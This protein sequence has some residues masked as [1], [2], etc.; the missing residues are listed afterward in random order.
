MPEG[1][2]ASMWQPISTTPASLSLG[3]SPA[4][5]AREMKCCTA[6]LK[7]AVPA[8]RAASC[9]AVVRRDE[10]LTHQTLRPVSG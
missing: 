10:V 4:A 1:F 3:K 2:S 6:S 9:V 7:S 8:G 5:T